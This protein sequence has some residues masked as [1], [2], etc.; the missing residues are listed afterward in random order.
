MAEIGK[1]A[2]I[3]G[4][5]LAVIAGLV[6]VSYAALILAVLGLIVGF[7]NV[8]EA[9]TTG[10]LIASIALMLTN[11]SITVIGIAILTAIF[12]NIAVFVAPA[13]LVV[14]VKAV[15]GTAASK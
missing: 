5:I 4:L 8:T 15:Y 14:A 12:S 6:T 7:L 2:F 1:W 13:A 10:F 3:V 11:A 9:E